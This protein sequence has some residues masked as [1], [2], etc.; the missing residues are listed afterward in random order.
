MG[1]A[2]IHICLMALC[3]NAHWLDGY[4]AKLIGSDGNIAKL[5]GWMATLPS[6]LVGKHFAHWLD[7][8]L[9]S[10]SLVGWHFAK[11]IGWM[12][13]GSLDGWHFAIM[14]IGWMSSLPSSLVG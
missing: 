1:L 2:K 12:A 9:P 7:G 8:T 5:I 4:F 10:C 13:L 3:Q 11:L 6:S 14:L